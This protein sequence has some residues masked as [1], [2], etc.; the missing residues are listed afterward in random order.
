MTFRKITLTCSLFLGALIFAFAQDMELPGLDPSPMDAAHYPPEAAYANYLEGEARN[1]REQIKVLY[2][3]PQKKEREI[4]GALVPYGQDWRLGANEGTEVTFY[5]PVEIN[6]TVVAPGTYTI[7][8]TIFP[9]KWVVKISSERFIAGTAN[10]DPS[11]VV[12]AASVPTIGL[13]NSREALTIGFQKIDDNN[14]NMVFEWDR[15]RVALPINLSPPNLPPLDAS[16]MDLAQYPNMSRF[17][18]FIEDEK[19]LAANEAKVRVVYSR[20]QKKGRTIFGELVKYGAPWRLGANE[21]TEITFFEDVMIGGTEVKAGTYGLMAV[22][23]QDN[24]EFI[25]HKGIP[26]WGD[27]GHDEKNNVAK[28]SSAVEKMSKEVE[29]LSMAFEKKDDKTVHLVVAWDK[30]MARLPIKMK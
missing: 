22:V 25:V 12:V 28:V 13:P 14:C 27:Y 23:N 15:T 19:E 20:P 30:T 17:R 7:N 16:P 1:T 2:S 18:N 11:K 24:W 10:L 6:H 4:F 26:S 21:T 9:D 5:S 8:A 3:R 29:G